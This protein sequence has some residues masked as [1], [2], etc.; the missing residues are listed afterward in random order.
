MKNDVAI[1]PCYDNCCLHARTY[2]KTIAASLDRVSGLPGLSRTRGQEWNSQT[3]HIRRRF[4]LRD[5]VK[6][7]GASTRRNRIANGSLQI[8]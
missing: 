4:P 3:D 5:G 7:F 8:L 6:K 1:A 2:T